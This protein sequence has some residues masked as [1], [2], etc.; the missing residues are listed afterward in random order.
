MRLAERKAI[1][2]PPLSI[3]FNNGEVDNLVTLFS[4]NMKK[5][6]LVFVPN[7]KAKRK[8]WNDFAAELSQDYQLEYFESRE[9]TSARIRGDQMDFTV[10][11]MGLDLAN[12][13]NK[14]S[15]PYHLVGTSIGACSIIKAW[16]Q[17][18]QKPKSL[19][20]ICPVV[21]L[22]LP[23]YFRLFPYIP[24]KF[25]IAFTPLIYKALAKTK[26]M[27]GV[28]RSLYHAFQEKDFREFQIMRASVRDILKMRIKLEEIRRIKVSSLIIYAEKDRIHS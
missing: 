24:E 10:E 13:L 4:S 11:Q 17:I 15:S 26:K 14:F 27:K 7:W 12:Y 18:K 9:K 22:K 20:L 8:H 3:Y 16:D 21:K 5:D 28:S 25:L 1:N 23:I 19:T 6:R 2:N